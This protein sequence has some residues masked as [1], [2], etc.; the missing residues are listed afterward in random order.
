LYTAPGVMRADHVLTKC[1]SKYEEVKAPKS[2]V[3]AASYQADA[4]QSTG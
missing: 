2:S 3:K 1:P 4:E